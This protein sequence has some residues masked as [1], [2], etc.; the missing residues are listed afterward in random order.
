MGRPLG[1]KSRVVKE[2]LGNHVPKGALLPHLKLPGGCVDPFPTCRHCD[3]AL[4]R[5]SIGWR[6]EN[7]KCPEWAKVQNQRVMPRGDG[8]VV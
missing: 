8:N 3:G 6:C 4:T 1:K 7:L 2:Y 5:T